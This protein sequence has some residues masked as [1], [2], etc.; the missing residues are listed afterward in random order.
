MI[1]RLTVVALCLLAAAVLET[2]LFPSLT[3]A[4]FRPDLLL[5]VVLAFGLHD[6][7]MSGA[8]VGFAAG[9]LADLLAVQAPVGLSVLVYTGIGH[10]VGL[11]RPYLAQESF[12]APLILAFLAGLLGTGGYGV[13]VLLLGEER[14]T[15]TLLLQASLS[16]ALYNTL[17][18]PVVLGLVDRLTRRFPLRGQATD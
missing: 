12:T 13:L 6:G 17:L 18:A 9:L 16:V 5:L 15:S 10:A 3:L 11:A 14:V 7:P 2:A 1:A 8:R 4:G